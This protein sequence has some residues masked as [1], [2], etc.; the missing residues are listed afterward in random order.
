M[1][2]KAFKALKVV[3]RQALIVT[4]IRLK[5]RK[6]PNVVLGSFDM[7]FF[8]YRCFRCKGKLEKG[9]PVIRL[10]EFLLYHPE[11]YKRNRKEAFEDII[12]LDQRS[13]EETHSH[14]DAFKN[15]VDSDSI[16]ESEAFYEIWGKQ[17][18]NATRLSIVM[19]TA[20]MFGSMGFLE[21]IRLKRR[22]KQYRNTLFEIAAFYRE[23]YDAFKI[24][25]RMKELFPSTGEPTIEQLKEEERK[26]LKEL[27]SQIIELLDNAETLYN[28]AKDVS[29]KTAQRIRKEFKRQI[30]EIPKQI[31][32][33]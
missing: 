19:S 24:K 8:E 25:R 16:S 6:N 22:L 13:L 30:R 21:K 10:S 12:K 3:E 32:T 14:L 2:L 18:M 17:L 11:C 26:A 4:S 5:W 20:E 29:R 31:E 15:L 23:V 1:L 33:L 27:K 28:D 9:N 7:S